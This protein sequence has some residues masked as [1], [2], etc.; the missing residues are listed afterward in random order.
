MSQ[1]GK[2]A[3]SKTPGKTSQPLAQKWQL[4]CFFYQIVVH[5]RFT[6]F[7][8]ACFCKQWFFLFYFIFLMFPDSQQ[9][10]ET[11]T[12]PGC[13]DAWTFIDVSYPL[14][15]SSFFYSLRLSGLQITRT[16]TRKPA[17]LTTEINNSIPQKEI[18]QYPKLF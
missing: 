1:M 14:S 5:G 16:I 15:L 2:T 13:G 9:S 3:E 6:D 7:A 8:R 4:C 11:M 17:N 18:T 10:S 12:K